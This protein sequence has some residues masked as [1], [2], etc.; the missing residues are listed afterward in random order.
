MK[1][2]KDKYE[3]LLKLI[4]TRRANGEK[5]FY[6]VEVVFPGSM[7]PTVTVTRKDAGETLI[8]DFMQARSMN[9]EQIIVT[10]YSGVSNNASELLR[11]EFN[12]YP[13]NRMQLSGMQEFKQPETVVTLEKFYNDRISSLSAVLQKDFEIKL[14]QMEL[15][16]KQ[17]RIAELE[18]ELKETEEYAEELEAEA[19]NPAGKMT[20]AGIN[21]G[22]LLSY[23]GENILKRNPGILK[24][25]LRIDDKQVQGL[26][27]T[28][29]EMKQVEE[30]PGGNQ[31]TVKVSEA[32]QQLTPEQQRQHQIA[33][34]LFDYFKKIPAGQLRLH[35]EIV[36]AVA[37][38]E[39]KLRKLYVYLQSLN[40]PETKEPRSRQQTEKPK[41]NNVVNMYENK[42]E[43]GDGGEETEEE[44]FTDDS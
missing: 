28:G 5:V 15:Q 9:P 7:N 43:T 29:E 40:S 17:E 34:Y 16:K 32:E 38:D 4:E 3:Q 42:Q 10:L 27:G 21:I 14:L 37:G 13:E 31:S 18:K 19:Q 6:S 11:K 26:W 2:F 20:L 25:V 36:A 12:V 1:D 41:E 39:M 44:E 23:A 22:D 33:A 8:S 24:A 30:S 35:Y